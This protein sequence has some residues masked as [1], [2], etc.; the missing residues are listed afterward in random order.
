MIIDLN[1]FYGVI[2]DTQSHIFQEKIKN[3]R[4][5]EEMENNQM[6]TNWGEYD[7]EKIEELRE[8]YYQII[9]QLPMKIELFLIEPMPNHPI[10]YLKWV[11]NDLKKCRFEMYLPDSPMEDHL[12]LKFPA[13]VVEKYLNFLSEE[14]R[15]EIEKV[16]L[17]SSAGKNTTEKKKKAKDKGVK[18][19]IR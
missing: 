11:S 9:N 2:V 16:Y 7:A 5:I 14:E 10:C 12:Q 3:M 4:K 13:Q 6:K 17:E 18:E 8:R 1:P 15:N 19:Y